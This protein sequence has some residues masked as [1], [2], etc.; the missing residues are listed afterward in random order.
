MFTRKAKQ[1]DE[2]ISDPRFPY[3]VGRL[4]GASEGIAHWMMIQD[5]EQM[6]A[7]GVKLASVAGWFFIDEESAN[8]EFAGILEQRPDSDSEGR[9][10][11]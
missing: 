2:L 6:K 4:L 10:G 5:D 8:G 7:M 9:S 1:F 11:S 3:Y